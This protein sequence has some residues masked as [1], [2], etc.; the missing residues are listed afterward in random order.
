MLQVKEAQGSKGRQL[1]TKAAGGGSLCYLGCVLGDRGTE[2][3][4]WAVSVHLGMGLK[5]ISLGGLSDL[6]LTDQPG[7]IFKGGSVESE[8]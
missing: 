8:V 2:G 5:F 3:W 7:C 4:W 1:N 6:R